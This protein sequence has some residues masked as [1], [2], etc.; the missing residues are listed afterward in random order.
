MSFSRYVFYVVNSASVTYHL[1]TES[2]V[3]TG[4]SQTEALMYWLSDSKVNTSWP[5]AEI[6]C[7]DWTDEVNKFIIFMAFLV[8]F[9]KRI[10]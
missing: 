6:S 1:L 8:L 5:R 9:L 3:I 10:Y 2:E 4:K 7:N